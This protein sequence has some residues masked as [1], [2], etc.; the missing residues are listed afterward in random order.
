MEISSALRCLW[1]P[2]GGGEGAGAPRSGPGAQ[3]QG[4]EHGSQ[5]LHSVGRPAVTVERGEGRGR[6]SL[7]NFCSEYKQ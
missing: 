7:K 5:P 3:G 2:Q 1:L 6:V 4:V